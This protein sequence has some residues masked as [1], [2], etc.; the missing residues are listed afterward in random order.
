MERPQSAV[1]FTNLLNHSAEADH[2]NSKTQHCDA[3]MARSS[4]NIIKPNGSLDGAQDSEITNELPRPYNC[5]LCDKSFR[6][7]EHQIRH[8]RTHTGEKPYVC[9]FPGCSMNFSRS[10][11]LSR[12]SRIHNN[13]PDLRRSNQGQH[14]HRHQGLP[15]N[16]HPEGMMASTWTLA[17]PNVPPPHSLASFA[18][19]PHPAPKHPANSGEAI[20][21]LAKIGRAHV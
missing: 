8:I 16:I 19:Q 18:Q 4:V 17:S 1:N 21:M 5:T 12:H 20:S 7:L 3:A 15:P 14:L 11:E 13:N 2:N 10:D 9:Q 6:R